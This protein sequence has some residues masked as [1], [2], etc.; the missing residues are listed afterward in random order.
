VTDKCS[1]LL[2]KIHEWLEGCADE[3]TALLVQWHLR[4]CVHCQQI[5]SEWQFVVEE[6]RFALP[7]TPPE[8]FEERLKQRISK[9]QILS[10]CELAVSWALTSTGVAI[11]VFWFGSSLASV[12]RSLFQWLLETINWSVLLTVWLQQFLELVNRW[13]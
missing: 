10:W 12:L 4:D 9:P 5:V 13:V 2:P 7:T 3:E 11:T 8:G 1:K 6:I